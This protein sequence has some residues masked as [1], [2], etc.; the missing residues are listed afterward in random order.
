MRGNWI[1]QCWYGVLSP[2]YASTNNPSESLH[3]YLSVDLPMR[4]IR[5]V[6]IQLVIP[7]LP[8]GARCVCLAW[9]Y[10]CSRSFLLYVSL[11]TAAADACFGRGVAC[12]GWRRSSLERWEPV[13]AK[14]A[15]AGLVDGL[16][17]LHFHKKKCGEGGKDLR[18][19]KPKQRL[20]NDA[21]SSRHG[22]GPG[23]QAVSL[24][25]ISR[26]HW[27]SCKSL[28]TIKLAPPPSL[29]DQSQEA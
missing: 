23:S 19:K 15:N 10:L 4:R 1:A 27:H 22:H 2:S 11:G 5:A 13:K 9:K 25:P 3:F 14:R 12:V 16:G 20:L 26:M 7:Q 6:C 17:V 29:I 21:L 24:T 28:G 8:S 18:E